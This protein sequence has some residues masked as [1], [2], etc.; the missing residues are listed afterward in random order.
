MYINESN[1]ISRPLVLCRSASCAEQLPVP[2]EASQVTLGQMTDSWLLVL[3]PIGIVLAI[4]AAMQFLVGSKR[5]SIGVLV[6]IVVVYALGVCV[7]LFG[8]PL[9]AQ[10]DPPSDE[11]TAPS[12]GGGLFGA[13]LV[14]AA[15]TPG[16]ATALVLLAGY[17]VMARIPRRPNRGGE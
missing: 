7:A 13:F 10:I 9:L 17:W 2:D 6:T 1:H 12:I 16:I 4:W 11:L 3:I 5:V 8:A 15:A 14:L